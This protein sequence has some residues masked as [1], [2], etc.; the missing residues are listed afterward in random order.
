MPADAL[1]RYRALLGV[2]AGSPSLGH[3]R[4]LVGAQLRRVPFENIS[5]LWR[6]KRYGSGVFPSLA[7]HLD[8]IEHHHFG[9]T[10]YANNWYFSKLLIHLG[11]DV[12]FCGAAMANPDVHTVLMV[13]IDGRELLVDV[14]YSAPFFEPVPRDL[15]RDFEIPWG[16]RRYVFRPPDERGNT[17]LDMYRSGTL[18]HG[19][20]AS[21]EPRDIDHF[22]DIVAD[23]YR[24]DVCFMNALVVER[25]FVGRS[26]RLHNLEL[27]LATPESSVVIEL[28]DGDPAEVV[29]RRFGIAA[30][31]VRE[32]IDGVS[33]EAD[34]YS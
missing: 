1:D 28:V 26:L 21:P 30:S 10:C 16:G 25:F 9:G 7:D 4:R 18:T 19:Y 17:R 15:D 5:K 22:A 13:R 3:L 8:G 32:A 24:S 31:I 20:L 11:Y 14:G 29:E 33:L 34:I 27:T 6:Q 23:S 12:R 2:D